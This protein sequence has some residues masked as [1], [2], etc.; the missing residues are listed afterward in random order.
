MLTSDVMTVFYW[1]DKI[2]PEPGNLA[3]YP[4]ES[5]ARWVSHRPMNGVVRSAS[6]MRVAKQYPD[7]GFCLF[8]HIRRGSQTACGARNGDNHLD[9]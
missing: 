8:G 2:A 4:T 1:V 6:S 9:I 5:C 3:R 7:G